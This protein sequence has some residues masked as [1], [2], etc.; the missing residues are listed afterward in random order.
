MGSSATGDR[1]SYGMNIKLSLALPFNVYTGIPLAAINNPADLCMF[2]EDDLTVVPGQSAGY[3]GTMSRGG[4][5]LGYS[6]VWY[7][8]ASAGGYTPTVDD[9]FSGTYPTN[10]DF[11]TPYA[12][13]FGGANVAY[14]DGHVK[15]VTYNN[16]YN[17]PAGT[18]PANFRLWHPDAL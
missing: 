18:T 3:Q 6:N 2:V 7:A 17:P 12:R 13:H 14:T 16:L 8:S 15:W 11:A 9:A 4:S 1:E 10:A 5:D